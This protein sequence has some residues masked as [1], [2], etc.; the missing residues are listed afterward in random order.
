[1]SHQA[2]YFRHQTL[3]R[4]KQGVQLGSVQAVTRMSPGYKSACAMSWMT[5]ARPSTVPAETARPISAPVGTSSRM[6]T[7]AR[8][9]P[10]LVSTRGGRERCDP[11]R[12]RSIRARIADEEID[13]CLPH[14][15]I[16]L[17]DD[18]AVR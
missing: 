16:I 15:P 5:R 11:G 17:A 14:A 8:T 18:V 13:L 7:P 2:P 10:S 3:D 1:M 12:P 4:G 9:S 6:Y